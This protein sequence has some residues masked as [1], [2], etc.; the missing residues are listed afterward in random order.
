M[1]NMEI[2]TSLMASTG[3]TGEDSIIPWRKL[4]W[5]FENPNIDI[6]K[7][8]SLLNKTHASVLKLT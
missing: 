3:T 7:L 8:I 4:E 5:W 1:G 6:Y 2:K